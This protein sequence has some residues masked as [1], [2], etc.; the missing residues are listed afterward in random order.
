V[1]LRWLNEEEEEEEEEAIGNAPF[2]ISQQDCLSQDSCFSCQEEDG[3]SAEVLLKISPNH[4]RAMKVSIKKKPFEL[5]SYSSTT[6]SL[7]LSP[8]LFSVSVCFCWN[9]LPWLSIRG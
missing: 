3:I 2:S 9:N 6:L 7:L 5:I 4:M 8:K 1:L